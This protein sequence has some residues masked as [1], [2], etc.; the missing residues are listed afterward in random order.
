M[1]VK[2]P[3]SKRK[4]AERHGRRSETFAA[5]MLLLKGYRILGRRVKTRAGEID[6]VARSPSGVVC[7]I[8]VKARADAATAAEAVQM[9]QQIRIARAAELFLSA[10]PALANA[11]FRFD[12]VTVSR[13]SL[14]RHLRDAWQMD[15]LKR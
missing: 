7:F 11:R 4:E 6:L 2:A 12:I 8:E 15:D 14:P 10:R 5:A 3:S 1:M 13:R 9:R